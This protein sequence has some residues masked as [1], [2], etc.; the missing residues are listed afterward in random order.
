M[1]KIIIGILFSVGI[2][3]YSINYYLK[4]RQNA[5]YI[6]ISKNSGYLEVAQVEAY[7]GYGNLLK[8]Y[9]IIGSEGIKGSD[10]IPITS[11]V[12]GDLS[13][14]KT[15][16]TGSQTIGAPGSRYISIDYGKL[17][18]IHKIIIYLKKCCYRNI[19]AGT[20]VAL[21]DSL[22]NNVYTSY[23]FPEVGNPT[24]T[25]TPERTSNFFEKGNDVIPYEI[26][27]IT[28]YPYTK[29]PIG[30]WTYPLSATPR[31]VK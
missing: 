4:H 23:P 22:G 17:V 3:L 13:K 31:I 10:K 27:T 18:N 6:V 9:N 15:F 26:F 29:L 30:E 1:I 8:P 12:D 19:M 24:R 14:N 5:Q 20:V 16:L 21:K 11:I 28:T 2:I 7:D 25:D